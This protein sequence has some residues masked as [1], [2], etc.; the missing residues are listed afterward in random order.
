MSF[1]MKGSPAKLGTIQGTTGHAASGG[2]LN[3]L[4]A[5]RKTLEEGSDEWKRVQN[6]INEALGSSK[7]YVVEGSSP[8]KVNPLVRFLVKQKNVK[9]VKSNVSQTVTR[10]FSKHKQTPTT[11]VTTTKG[12]TTTTITKSDKTGQTLSQGTTGTTGT[13]GTTSTSVKPVVTSSGGAKG[14]GSSIASLLK[15]SKKGNPPRVNP[16]K[17]G[18]RRPDGTRI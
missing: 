1:K 15:G 12:G 4:V 5:Q 18:Q 11:T 6:K 10:G 17:R 8:A 9:P 2:T 13:S 14:L 16:S 3:D 7:R